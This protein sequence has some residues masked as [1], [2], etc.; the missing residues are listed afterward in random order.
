MTTV[1]D[2]GLAIACEDKGNGQSVVLIPGGGGGP[3]H[4]DK[5]L[6]EIRVHLPDVR[7]IIPQLYG[8]GASPR[9]PLE[10]DITIDDHVEA[11]V[12]ALPQFDGPVMVVAHSI[13]G[14]VALQLA[15]DH[16]HLVSRLVLAEP[17]AFHMLR[18]TGRPEDEALL[19]DLAVVGRQL[20]EGGRS[21][22]AA[23]RMRTARMYIDYWNGVGRW[24]NLPVAMQ[25][26][27]IEMMPSIGSDFTSLY[28]H[29][30]PTTRYTELKVP[31]LIVRGGRSPQPARRIAE[32]LADVIPQARLAEIADAGHMLLLSHGA[33]LATHVREELKA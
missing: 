23:L 28:A 15:L 3:A 1:T 16:P 25:E 27:F 13:G 12:Q 7:S 20:A 10:R 9:W 14:A 2:S 4:W 32:L 19:E 30:V 29:H 17:T 22:D 26:A 11:V 21:T 6:A 18:S 33:K 8:Y 5:V 31:V 24:N